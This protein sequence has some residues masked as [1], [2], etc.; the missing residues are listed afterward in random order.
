MEDGAVA[1]VKVLGDTPRTPASRGFGTAP[2]GVDAVHFG[3]AVAR[4]A[5]RLKGRAWCEPQH[6]VN[7]WGWEEMREWVRGKRTGIV[8]FEAVSPYAEGYGLKPPRLVA[9]ATLVG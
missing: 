6:V 8:R 7:T 3:V 2:A 1:G 5:L 4:R 9:G